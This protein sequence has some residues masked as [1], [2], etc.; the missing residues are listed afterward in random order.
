MLKEG[1]DLAQRRKKWLIAFALFGVSTYIAYKAH[2]LP[3]VVRKRKRIVKL[4]ET[5]VTMAEMVSDSAETIGIVSKDLKE[6]LQ[7]DSDKI[8][9]NLKQWSKIARSEE[10]CRVC[11]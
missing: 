7:S 4:L 1:M 5:L 11:G 2:H 6:F 8:P 3:S 10:F 9:N